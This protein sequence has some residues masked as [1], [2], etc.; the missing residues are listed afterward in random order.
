MT[1]QR[2]AHHSQPN[3]T[4]QEYKQNQT[5]KQSNQQEGLNQRSN[6]QERPRYQQ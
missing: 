4:P 3:Q 2:N 6:K 1:A 5:I